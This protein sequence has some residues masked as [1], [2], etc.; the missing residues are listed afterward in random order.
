MTENQK[1]QKAVEIAEERG[2]YSYELHD[3]IRLE[4]I[5]DAKDSARQILARA[6]R[7]INAKRG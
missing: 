1:T 5:C 6:L 2:V 3:A 4:A 7:S